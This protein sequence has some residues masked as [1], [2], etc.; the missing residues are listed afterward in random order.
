MY[1]TILGNTNHKLKSGLSFVYDELEQ[2]MDDRLPNDTTLRN[3]DRT[4][5]VPGL[6]SEY[7]YTG[8]RS[9]VVLGARVDYHNLYEWQFT[10]RA[11]YK[12]DLTENIYI[13]DRK[14]TRLN[15]SHVRISYAVF[16][17]NNK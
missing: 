14:S 7:T 15:S 1:E 13:R 16:C 2:T 8:T 6:F 11:N 5:I 17:L 4:E 9:I 3:F 12:F 10:P